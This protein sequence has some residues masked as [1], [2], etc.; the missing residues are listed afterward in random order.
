MESPMK[1]S[2]VSGVSLT[3]VSSRSARTFQFASR[4]TGFT[5]ECAPDCACANE[6]DERMEATMSVRRVLVIMVLEG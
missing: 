3:R 4:G 2:S 6:M 1:S 5:A